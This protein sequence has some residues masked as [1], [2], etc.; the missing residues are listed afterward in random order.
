MTLNPLAGKDATAAAMEVFMRIVNAGSP[1]GL[2]EESFAAVRALEPAA[3]RDVATA[4]EK[5]LVGAIMQAAFHESQKP[6]GALDELEIAA[7]EAADSNRAIMQ[8]IHR[9]LML[10]AEIKGDDVQTMTRA[11]LKEVAALPEGRAGSIRGYAEAAV[12]AWSHV[13][14]TDYPDDEA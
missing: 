5:P 9:A 1:A 10:V 13:V 8:G 6:M 3:R 2:P 12:R 11:Y 14:A 7:I 4:L